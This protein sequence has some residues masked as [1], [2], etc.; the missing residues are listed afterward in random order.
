MANNS[1]VEK[2][3]SYRLLTSLQPYEDQHHGCLCE[4]LVLQELLRIKD[5]PDVPDKEQRN[6]HFCLGILKSAL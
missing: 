6:R 5:T 3:G 2:S 1:Q 4:G